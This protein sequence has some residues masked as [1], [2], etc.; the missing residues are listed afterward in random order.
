MFRNFTESLFLGY[1][2]SDS[3]YA[4]DTNLEKV[5]VHVPPPGKTF[6]IVCPTLPASPISI[7]SIQETQEAMHGSMADTEV[8]PK[9]LP[10]QCCLLL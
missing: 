8:A 10:K 1:E 3:G 2:R 6:L 4:E 9:M 7:V 5:A